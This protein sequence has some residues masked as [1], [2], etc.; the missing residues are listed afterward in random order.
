VDVPLEQPVNVLLPKL[1]PFIVDGSHGVRDQLN[2]LLRVLPPGDIEAHSEKLL[3]YI[4]AGM[5]HLAADIRASSMDVL[6]WAL[7][8]AGDSIV[9]AAGGW[10]KTLNYFLTMLGWS[11]EE[12]NVSWSRPNASFNKGVDGGKAL[13]K[14]LSV[15]GG[16]LRCGL[17]ESDENNAD[18]V[19][20]FPLVHV[21]YHLLPRKSNCFAH[22][23]LFASPRTDKNEIYEDREER[24]K[25]FCEVFQRAIERGLEAAQQEGG[26]VG[27]AA[28]AVKGFLTEALIQSAQKEA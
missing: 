13:A 20:S 16:F 9:S 22:L 1:L 23:N 17:A 8:V 14:T 11:K 27:R 24:Q 7:D 25:V 18:E 21:Q 15:L 3:I 19:I 6:A 2:K 5:T 12:V 4:R 28:A 26:E 10:V